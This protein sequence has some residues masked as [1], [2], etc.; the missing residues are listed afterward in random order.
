MKQRGAGGAAISSVRCPPAGPRR[1]TRAVESYAEESGEREP[2]FQGARAPRW[3]RPMRMP[4]IDLSSMNHAILS[5][6]WRVEEDHKK[7]TGSNATMVQEAMQYSSFAVRRMRKFRGGVLLVAAKSFLTREQLLH[8]GAAS[9]RGS[10]LYA[11][12]ASE[13][14]WKRATEGRSI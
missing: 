9:S 5:A 10:C 6:S 14:F 11:Y 12:E 4:R 7:Y 13:R 8:E 1:Y 2:L 3:R